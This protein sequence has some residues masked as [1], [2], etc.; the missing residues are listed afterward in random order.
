MVVKLKEEEFMV[1]VEKKPCSCS[2]LRP[3]CSYIKKQKEEKTTKISFLDGNLFLA[4]F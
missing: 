3:S 1:K 2:Y 4:L